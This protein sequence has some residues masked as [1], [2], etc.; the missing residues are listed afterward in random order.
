LGGPT[1]PG[2]FD[3]A[4]AIIRGTHDYA[5]ASVSIDWLDD[6]SGDGRAD[7]AVGEY[8]RRQGGD[9]EGDVVGAAYLFTA[10][11][12][13]TFATA[14]AT[15]TLEGEAVNAAFGYWVTGLSDVDGDELTD[16]GVGAYQADAD[17]GR[18]FLF[19]GGRP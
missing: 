3:D 1:G 4:E 9:P 15:L 5:Y 16:L 6:A 10:P 19:S 13:G 7:L 17:R 8:G 11:V 18:V 2:D 12:S 14:A